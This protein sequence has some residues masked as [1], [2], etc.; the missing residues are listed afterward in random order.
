MKD[1]NIPIVEMDFYISMKEIYTIIIGHTYMKHRE[2][3]WVKIQS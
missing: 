1:A 2:V 3:T